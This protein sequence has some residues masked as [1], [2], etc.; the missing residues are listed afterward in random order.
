MK[1]FF[2]VL[3]V[4]FF[5]ITPLACKSS[6]KTAPTPVPEP[7]PIQRIEI[8]PVTNDEETH[9]APPSGGGIAEEIRRLTETGTLASMYEAIDLIRGRN[10]GGSEFGRVM[11]AVN[12]TLIKGV[13]GVTDSGLPIPDLP[14]THLYARILRN[15]ER[16]TY[17]APPPSSADYLECLLP[18]LALLDETRHEP[19][20]AARSDVQKAQ[21]LRPDSVLAP[22]FLGLLH[23]RTGKLEE[24]AEAYA[25]A[26]E[27]S[28]D[29]YPA[30]LGLSR[31]MELSGRDREA[32][33]ILSKLLSRHPG[34]MPVMRQLALG[35]YK[36]G[37]WQRAEPIIAEIL[38]DNPR[39]G[40]FLLMRARILVESGQYTQAQSSLDQYASFSP[41]TALYL[42][43]R[44]RI[45]AEA[46]YNREQALN[47]LHTLL[48]S[49]PGD[50]EAMLYAARLLLESLDSAEQAEG[51]QLLGR[52]LQNDSPTLDAYSLAL[53][54][55]INRE[56]WQEARG[57]MTLLFA[58][59][60]TG[61]DL[62][63]AYLVEKGLGNNDRALSY[64]REL[65]ERDTRD[66]N[67]ISAYISALID[68]GRRDAASRLIEGR[69]S[70]LSG[71]P[72]KSR[73][74]YLRSRIAANED[75]AAND[76]SSA[77]FEDPRNLYALIAMF[78]IFHNRKDSRRAVYYLKQA[79]AIAP[80]NPR[81]RQYEAEYGGLMGN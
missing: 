75:A 21:E 80:N 61:H 5:L 35:L 6:G 52:L 9:P 70:S 60:R 23:E 47:F 68:S 16:G 32:L 8:P 57:F 27:I 48:R 49:Y 46:F 25:R 40:E 11:N 18:F 22:Y 26:Q 79:L 29:C 58:Q 4:C 76:L 69:L 67:G 38:R 54:D 50:E 39:N 31:V 71:G 30:A 42:F 41:F 51:R 24:A 62:Y 45:Q 66:D 65:Y 2:H 81:L 34:S 33:D 14:Q 1:P 74:F 37:D 78:E 56:N 36:A 10:L 53:Q 43:L 12:T 77:L 17:T 20:L 13:Y 72:V 19:L 28:D 55:A 73:Y 7:T 3:I 44:A 59:R 64:A 15:A 63:N